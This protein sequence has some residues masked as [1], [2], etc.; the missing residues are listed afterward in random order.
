MPAA[1]S[2]RI[3]SKHSRR[4]SSFIRW[5]KLVK[6]HLGSLRAFFAIRCNFVST[7]SLLLCIAD[8]SSQHW[9]LVLI[10]AISKYEIWVLSIEYKDTVWFSSSLTTQHATLSVY[11]H[12]HEHEH[13]HVELN[14]ANKPNINLS[15][16]CIAPMVSDPGETYN[17]LP[18]APSSV[19][20]SAI[21]TASSLPTKTKPFG[22]QS[23]QPFGL[24]PVVL[25]SY[26]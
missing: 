1:A 23:L 18:F 13:V 16:F 17:D 15:L 7:V 2:L 10:S 22:A 21:L 8:V 12:E 6:L 11:V 3:R 26:A 25:L 14:T 19:E 20:T 5:N 4:N 9:G 24:R